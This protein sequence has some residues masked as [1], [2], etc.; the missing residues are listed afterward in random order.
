MKKILLVFFLIEINLVFAESYDELYFHV[1]KECGEERIQDFR[2]IWNYALK[3]GAKE[4]SWEV[5]KKL[6][7]DGQCLMEATDESIIL[8]EWENKI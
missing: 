6:L 5:V 4:V 8:Q 7:K 2:N 3:S 1:I